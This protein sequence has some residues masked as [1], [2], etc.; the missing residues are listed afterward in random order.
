MCLCRVVARRGVPYQIISDNAQQFK[1]AKAT[2]NRAWSNMLTDSD[3]ND[4]SV[5]QGIQWKFIVKLASRDGWVFM[6]GW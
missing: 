1:V 6:K 4:Y 3:V 5:R 2:L